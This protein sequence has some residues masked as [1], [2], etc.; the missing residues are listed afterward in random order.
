MNILITGGASG[1]GGAITRKLA[2]EPANYVYYTYNKS[3]DKA[4]IIQNTFSNAKCIK[5]DFTDP[6]EVDNLIDQMRNWDLQV[7]INNA[8]SGLTVNHFHKIEPSVFQDSF[9]NN[10]IPTIKITQQ[11]IQIFRKRKFGKIITVLSSLLVSTPPLGLSEYVANKAYLASLSKSWAVE[12]AAFN[13][14]SNC[15]SPSFMQT[16]LTR[17]TDERIIDEMIAKSPLKKLLTP[18]EVSDAV[19]C[20][21][22]ITQHINGINLVINSATDVV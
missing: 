12:N 19:L 7:L 15:I 5:C 21:M 10:I 6:A 20:L 16:N 1:L 11:A 17:D 9:I 22:N 3:F 2:T 4:E 13:I 18:E 8:I 14:T